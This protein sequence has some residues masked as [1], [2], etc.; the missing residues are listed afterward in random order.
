MYQTIIR[1]PGGDS[2]IRISPNTCGADYSVVNGSSL[3]VPGGTVAFVV[4][5]GKVS[6]PYEPGRHTLNTGVDPF[7]VRFKNLM[8]RGDAGITVSVFFV[9]TEKH[10]SLTFGTGE[11]PFAENR[12]GLTMNALA[13]CHL[14]FRVTA[15]AALLS[16]L[17]GTYNEI[18]TQD[19]LERC[20]ELLVLPSVRE[21]LATALNAHTIT[22]FN[23]K[24]SE[25]SN[26]VRGDI[27]R[28]LARYGLGVMEFDLKSVNVPDEE[29]ERLRK[30]QEMLA[31]G[32]IRTDIEDDKLKRI[33]GGDIDKRT[34]A[35]ML[36]GIPSRGEEGGGGP[37]PAPGHAAGFSAMIP[38]LMLPQ[39]MGQFGNA[40]TSMTEHS[41]LFGSHSGTGTPNNTSGTG[42][43]N[44]TA[45][46]TPGNT[47]GAAVPPPLPSRT[48]RCPSC[49]GEVSMRKIVCPICGHRF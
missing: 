33:W 2:L 48:K 30:L 42:T 37:A 32:M 25:I 28:K 29:M 23:S 12:F 3:I 7:F 47:S 31:E 40:V 34:M 22:T 39:L 1:D 17:V 38:Y 18:Y 41:N 15:P 46:G 5:N 35:E 20:V 27:G 19:D 44:S 10:Q 43:A 9:S 36:T 13:S 24:L 8:T 11:V 4:I 45:G 16:K 49:N 14:L 26:E 6:P 21:R